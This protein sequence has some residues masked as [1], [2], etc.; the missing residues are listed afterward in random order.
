MKERKTVV[1][2]G[3]SS[4]IG[5]ATAVRFARE[6]W[7]VCLVARREGLLKEVL[8]G[9]SK[10]NHLIC[11]GSYDNADQV[12]TMTR[13]IKQEWNHV[14]ALVNCAGVFATADPLEAPLELWR[15]PFE[16]MING[17]VLMTRMVVP[18]MPDG[19]RIIHVT[20]IHGERVEGGSSSY[21][22]AKAALNHYCRSLA[23]ELAPRNILVN[24]LAPG[25]VATP[26]SVVNGV[27][28]LET[29]GFRKNY[30]EGHHLPLKRAA[31]PQEIAGV[32]Y[33]LAGPDASYITGQVITVDGGLTITF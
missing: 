21:A 32:A 30:V 17:A 2:T 28:E 15:E 19:G 5:R 10:G 25:F 3:A 18:M 1:V 14:Q 12:H 27:D 20:S 9:L 6:G 13:T 26:M 29:E 4:G 11:P 16:V 33:F 7:D 24:A 31:Q 23:L 8:G 22:M